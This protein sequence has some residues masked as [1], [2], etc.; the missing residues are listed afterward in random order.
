MTSAAEGGSARVTSRVEVFTFQTLI[1]SRAGTI[2]K[3]GC[4]RATGEEVD[5][6]VQR[7]FEFAETMTPRLDDGE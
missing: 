5:G 7:I 3:V 4:A 1:D 2:A 6:E